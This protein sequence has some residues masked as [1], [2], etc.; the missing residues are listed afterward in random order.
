MMFSGICNEPVSLVER[1]SGVV[2]CVYLE[3]SI[4]L[5]VYLVWSIGLWEWSVRLFVYLE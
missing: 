1:V 3:W 5:F 2:V 4:G